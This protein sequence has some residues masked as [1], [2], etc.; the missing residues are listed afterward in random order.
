MAVSELIP[1]SDHSADG[2]LYRVGTRT[3]GGGCRGAAVDWNGSSIVH[4]RRFTS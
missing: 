2:L 3:C 1:E 4:D